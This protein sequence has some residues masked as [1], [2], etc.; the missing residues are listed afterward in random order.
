MKRDNQCA[1]EL[2]ERSIKVG[3]LIFGMILLRENQNDSRLAAERLT[4]AR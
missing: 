1:A 2:A 3:L 4:P